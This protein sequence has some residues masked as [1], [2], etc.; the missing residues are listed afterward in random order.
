[1]NFKEFYNKA[2]NRLTDAILSLWAT[3]DKEMQDYFKYLLEQEPIMAEAVFQSTFPW[4]QSNKT[5]EEC[6]MVFS[7]EF[8]SALDAIEDPEFK[9]PKSRPPYK[10]QLL[11]WQA[12][13]NQKK[14]IAVTTGTGS[15][16]T[17]CF[18]LPVLHDIYQNCKNQEGVNAIFLYPL[19]ALIA[20]QK[21]RMHAWCSALTGINY[22]LL[23]G[24]TER[25]VNNKDAEKAL[26]QLI[27][28]EQ[29]RK[30][31]PQILFTNPT[32]L[33]YMLVRNADVP[34]LEKSKGKLRWILLD[35]AHTLTGSKA[36]EMAL[37]IRRV[38]DAFGVNIAD[39]RFAITSATV[40]DGSADKLKKFMSDLCGI[41][42]DQIEVITGQRV[43][44]QIEDSDIPSLSKPL[45]QNNIK[46]LRAEFLKKQ[47]LS[48]SEIGNK[49]GVKDPGEQLE[50]IDT[51]ADQKI[52]GNNLLPVRGHFFTRGIG[53]V[54]VCT[55]TKCDKH[56]HSKPEAAMGTMYSIAGKNCTCGYPLLELVACRTCGNMMLEAEVS[57]RNGR[58]YLRQIVGVGHDAFHLDTENGEEETAPESE[59]ES[60][61]PANIVSLV[62]N[63]PGQRLYNRVLCPESI[64]R[65]GEIV[66]GDDWLLAENGRCPHCN[67]RNERPNHF[68][69]S[70]AFTNRIL[71]DIILDQ[72]QVGHKE[73]NKALYEGR[74]YISFTDSR[75][76]T[77]K[78]SALI[79]IDSESSWIRYQVYHHLLEKLMKSQKDR[80]YEQLLQERAY[81]AEQL[82]EAPPFLVGELQEKLRV[83]EEQIA[84]GDQLSL[85]KSRVA[86]KDIIEIILPKEDFK[87]LFF[88][89]AKGVNLARD[90]RTYASALLFDQFAR[91]LPRVRSLEN[92]G[93][94]NVVYPDLDNVSLPAIARN[95]DISLDEYRDLLKIAVDYV[96]RLNFHF[97]FE[98]SLRNFST[99]FYR[100]VLIFPPNSDLPNAIRWPQYNPDSVIQ[101]RLVLLICAGLG[102]HEKEDITGERE[103]QINDLLNNLWSTIR[104]RLLTEEKGGYK[105]NLADKVQFEIAGLEYL[106]PV[107]RRL[108]DK[109]F[110]GYSPWVTGALTSENISH[111]AIDPKYNN[112]LPAYAYPYHLN[113]ENVKV[114]KQLVEG[115]LDE[116]SVE[117][118]EKGLWNNLHERIF[119]F[120]KLYLAGE[121]SAQQDKKRLHELEGQ[122]ENGEI[123]ILSCS[124]TMEMGVDI[125][126]ISAVVMSNVPPMPANY[127]QRAGRAGRRS[128][129]KSMA[130]TF[131]A[132]NPVG[133][134]TMKEPKWALQHKIASPHLKFD[135]KNIVERHINSLL[136]GHFVRNAD[137]ENRGLNVVENVEN[138]FLKGAPTVG[139]TFLNWLDQIDASGFERALYSIVKDTP[140]EEAGPE[141]LIRMVYENFRKLSRGI[142]NQVEGF[143]LKLEELEKQFGNNSPAYKAVAYRKKQFETRFV[144]GYLAE[145]GFLPNA[146]LPTGIVEFEKTTVK[147]LDKNKNNFPGNPSYT[148][149]RALTEFAPGNS[150]LIDGLSYKSSGIVMKNNRGETGKR[151]LVQA[152]KKCGFQRS[153]VDVNLDD[154][155]VECNTPGAYVGI[156]LGAHRGAF[157]ELIEPV[158]FSVDLFSEATRV[159]SEKSKP[160][161]LEPLLLNIRPWGNEQN[162]FLDFRMSSGVE[163]SEILF[164]NQ[165][166]G[167]GYSV[168]LDCGRVET[169][170]DKLE[171]H[172]RLRGGK[173]GKGENRCSA[174]SVRSNVILGNRFKTDFTEIRLKDQDGAFVNDEKL[175]YS[176]GVIFTKTL[177]NYLAIDENE[178]GFGIKRYK[179]YRTIFIYDSAK[180]GAGYAS[181]FSM[182]TEE[183]LEE[184]YA[185]LKNCDCQVACTKCLVDRTTQWHIENLDRELAGNWLEAALNS[186]V[187]R[188]LKDADVKVDGIFGSLK[189]EIFRMDYHFGIKQ[190]VLHVNN[191]IADWNL[192]DLG[193][194][195]NIKRNISD[196]SVVVEG[197]LNYTSNQEKL[198]AHLL[199]HMYHLK[200]GNRQ[201]F[202]SYAVHMSV[203]LN[204]GKILDYISKADHSDLDAD[205]SANVEDSFYKVEHSNRKEYPVLKLPDLAGIK[206]FESKI[207]A[208][209]KGCMSNSLVEVMLQNLSDASDLLSKIKNQ[210]YTVSYFDKYNQSEF[211]LRLLLQFVQSFQKSAE[212]KVSELDVY[213]ERGAFENN[214]HPNYIIHNYA[215]I[216]DY[217]YDLDEISKHIDF[218]VDALVQERLPH[219]RYLEFKSAEITFQVRIDGGIAHGFKPVDFLRSQ[220]MPYDNIPLEIKKDVVHDI[221][222]NI[223]IEN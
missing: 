214:R 125:G 158:G 119:D 81:Y 56:G 34:V 184:A 107:K 109:V 9:F 206:L 164:Y 137:N 86:W 173:D 90:N 87:T 60:N 13:L 70:S 64:G 6:S 198:S 126:G 160:Q 142:H 212:I 80:S 120:D 18:M 32:M 108:L 156:D 11:S 105:L 5:F 128:E 22:A 62:H 223:S 111:F 61:V 57:K 185:V 210:T 68:R 67:V 168:C 92:L 35:E 131:C 4:E 132:P 30:S 94:V 44:N 117:S 197:N 165:G 193:W 97:L 14:S 103:D 95:L 66:S 20:S 2:Q 91:R 200:Q 187:P 179:D 122:F 113:D 54:Y 134:R 141:Q 183:I 26:P 27:S 53:G 106:C 112:Q 78:I 216:D 143:G 12:L 167:E 93:L 29:I 41:G 139:E 215:S 176:L 7:P 208:V 191:R 40:G 154:T 171:G 59:Q 152:C 58:S 118:R 102:W 110:R 75:Q 190:L 85:T 166:E 220:D 121:H 219:Y 71:S 138:F 100:S 98:G 48:Q 130:L 88:K 127:L 204:N 65:D 181:Q 170:H 82:Q 104:T 79:N 162:S 222:Y 129:N 174:T 194:L 202:E 96:I 146:G 123:N 31:P 50:I 213:L 77:A 145:E 144:L 151:L 155:C 42:I 84:G 147:D 195:E 159:I 46:T 209:P 124:T 23:T 153:V 161:Y 8:V 150:I 182:Y 135:S 211:S 133:L 189:D 218:K 136:F 28:R 169:D 217:K 172:T 21:K 39:L 47:A 207:G 157:T 205:W 45:T 1:M 83:V 17:E 15:G 149:E 101:Q 178:L 74:K 76:G 55:N 49:L 10:H 115:W 114:E 163:N 43:N 203:M 33:E 89:A 52:K 25:K 72:T 148:I 199:S 221:I 177:S 116:N 196:I 192:D 99:A 19:N 16:K 63:K 188:E 180:G 36:A 37:L 51:L 201:E 175:M 69:V 140:L 73:N 38:A 3:G 24:D 186:S